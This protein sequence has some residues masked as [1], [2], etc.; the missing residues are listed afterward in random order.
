ML[1][2]MEADRQPNH[3]G[4]DLDDR[5]GDGQVHDNGAWRKLPPAERQA[6]VARVIAAGGWLTLLST[7]HDDDLLDLMAIVR[8][9]RHNNVSALSLVMRNGNPHGM[10]VTAAKLLAEVADETGVSNEFLSVWSSLAADRP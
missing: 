8:A 4:D 1:T 6:H 10:L 3:D 2:V 7:P 5:I 9:V